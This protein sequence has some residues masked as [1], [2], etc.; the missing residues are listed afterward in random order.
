M[1]CYTEPYTY[2]Y[3]LNMKGFVSNIEDATLE[4]NYF[5]KVLFTAKNSQLVVMCLEPSQ[6][7]G[8]EVHEVD[9]FFRCETGWGKA[10]LDGKEFEFKDGWVIVIPAGVHHNIVNLSDIEPLRLYTLYCPPHHKDGTVHQTKAEAEKDT[11][12]YDGLTSF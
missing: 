8:D 11:E 4:N 10:V 1:A 6:E 5:R 12:E 3:H 2:I 9:Q 7:I